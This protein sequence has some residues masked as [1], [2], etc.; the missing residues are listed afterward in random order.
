[1]YIQNFKLGNMRHRQTTFFNKLNSK[2]TNI[3]SNLTSFLK[4]VF[5]PLLSL[6]HENITERQ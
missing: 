3:I 1:M 4:L 2:H 6:W 5:L